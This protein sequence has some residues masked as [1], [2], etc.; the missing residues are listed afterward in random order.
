MRQLTHTLSASTAVLRVSPPLMAVTAV[1]IAELPG[2]VGWS[3]VWAESPPGGTRQ[4]PHS[5]HTAGT[6]WCC[7]EPQHGGAS[8]GKHCCIGVLLSVDLG[9][10]PSS[11]V[12]QAALGVDVVLGHALR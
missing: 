9:K 4:R 11:H 5:E 7:S 8:Q 12:A 10:L 1:V 3:C 2:F 6:E